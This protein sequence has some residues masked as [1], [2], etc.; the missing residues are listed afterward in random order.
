MVS[1]LARA[2]T[3][4]VWGKSDRGASNDPPCLEDLAESS[5]PVWP[6]RATCEAR[7]GSK[8]V[9][10]VP[11]AGCVA[12]AT[13]LA[14]LKLRSLPAATKV[15]G[16][17]FRARFFKGK[18]RTCTP[19]ITDK[20]ALAPWQGLVPDAEG[21]LEYQRRR[22]PPC[23]HRLACAAT[24]RTKFPVVLQVAAPAG[25]LLHLAHVI[26]FAASSLPSRIALLTAR[27][28]ILPIRSSVGAGAPQS[29]GCHTVPS[30][31]CSCSSFFPDLA[32]F[33]H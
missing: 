17:A 1:L 19:A 10:R 33:P 29:A 15:G 26:H 12:K 31:S 6:M 27:F 2:K 3:L 4:G 30:S 8:G 16:D 14:F 21:S 13:R 28:G 5:G 9:H 23:R 24:H 7:Q 18:S 32:Y 22:P 20:D 25:G 11:N